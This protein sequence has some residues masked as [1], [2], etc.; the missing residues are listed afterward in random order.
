MPVEWQKPYHQLEWGTTI[1]GLKHLKV[2]ARD[3]FF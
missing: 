1:A 3:L 2:M